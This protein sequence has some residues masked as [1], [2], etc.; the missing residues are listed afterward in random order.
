MASSYRKVLWSRR[1]VRHACSA[2]RQ[3][4]P[5]AICCR[6]S[7][8]TSRQL[9]WTADEEAQSLQPNA[10]QQ[11]LPDK[12][13]LS[14]ELTYGHEPPESQVLALV[15]YVLRQFGRLRRRHAKLAVLTARV[16]LLVDTETL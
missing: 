13:N 16:H 7:F 11:A 9:F 2:K 1:V 15:V 12:P 6:L 10:R 3:G 4:C 5:D 14:I 8:E